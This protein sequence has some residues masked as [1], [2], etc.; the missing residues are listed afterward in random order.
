MNKI[1]VI[2]DENFTTGFE[3]VGCV[4]VDIK[5]LE[6]EILKN[7]RFGIIVI[8]RKK[9]ELLNL[10]VK[11][12]IENCQKPIIIKMSKNLEEGF[13]INKLIKKSLGIEIKN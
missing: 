9:F 12:L 5:N 1:G 6:D 4:K 8:E 7:K 2:G 10:R 11:N 13:D 3:I